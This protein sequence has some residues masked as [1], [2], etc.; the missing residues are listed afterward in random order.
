MPRNRNL[1]AALD[2]EKGR[3]VTAEKRQ[4][5][6]KAAEK[7]KREQARLAKEATTLD[8]EDISKSPTSV[9]GASSHKVQ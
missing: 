8:G 5:Q 9:D 7:R 6:V 3:D 1:L 2:A 4:K